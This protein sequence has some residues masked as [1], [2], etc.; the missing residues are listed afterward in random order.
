MAQ[1]VKP[2][3]AIGP[4]WWRYE[5]QLSGKP[6]TITTK[7]PDPS[8]AQRI[9]SAPAFTVRNSGI[10]GGLLRRRPGT[11]GGCAG[12]GKRDQASAPVV[13]TGRRHLRVLAL[14][15]RRVRAR[16]EP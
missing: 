10:G 14:D 3:A 9:F 2:A 12:L 13:R 4:I 6:C 11:L 15:R 5:Y 8:M 16:P 7:G 1:A